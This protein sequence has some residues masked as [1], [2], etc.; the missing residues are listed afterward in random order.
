ME[1]NNQSESV[2]ATTVAETTSAVAAASAK[3]SKGGMKKYI[4]TALVVLII[5]AGLLFVLEREGRISTN[6]FSFLNGNDSAAIVNG[7]VITKADFDSSLNQLMQ[8]AATQGAS[9]TDPAIMEQYRTQAIDTLINGE[10]LRQAALAAGMNA[11]ADAITA[12]FTEI[13]TGLGGKEQ[14]VAKM[15]EFGITET[16]LRRDIENEILIQG[17]FDSKFP[18]NTTEV[19]EEEISALY[20]ELGGE[21]AGIPPLSEVKEQVAE[22]IKLDRQ[23]TQISEYIDTLRSEAKIEIL[24]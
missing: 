12:R 20:A 19:S 3:K 4:I 21:G 5:G 6:L 14:L 9:T 1:D 8:M 22:Q 24:I 7:S 15:A 13:E 18:L 16:V 10:L 17:L 23:Q 2:E 11:P